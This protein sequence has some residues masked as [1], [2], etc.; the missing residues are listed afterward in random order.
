MSKK[1]RLLASMAI[2]G[3]LFL[4]VGASIAFA[5]PGNAILDVTISSSN[6]LPGDVIIVTFTLS[7]MDAA[8]EFVDWRIRLG[9]DSSILDLAGCWNNPHVWDS[10]D[11]AGGGCQDNPDDVYLGE[12]NFTG[13]STTSTPIILGTASFTVTS[14]GTSDF[15]VIMTSESIDTSFTYPGLPPDWWQP[16]TINIEGEPVPVGQVGLGN[17]NSFNN[18]TLTK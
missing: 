6:P 15:L 12:G 10:G 2:A 1:L 14:M 17:F 7:S 9:Y 3:G 5:D 13:N 11:G 4:L 18:V 16:C 8:E